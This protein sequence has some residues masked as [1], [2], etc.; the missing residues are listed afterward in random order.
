MNENTNLTTVDQV[1][2]QLKKAQLEAKRERRVAI[3]SL[4][5]KATDVLSDVLDTT[6]QAHEN[7][8]LRAA[9]VAINLYVQ[10]DNSDRQ[11]RALDLQE[12]RL[13]IEEKKLGVGVF[14]QQNNIFLPGSPEEKEQKAREL[15][16]RKKV[17]D[18]LLESFLAGSP[19]QNEEDDDEDSEDE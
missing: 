12:K 5:D 15:L 18:K 8:R 1:E 4:L 13:D 2:L 19:N 10:Q 6:D 17:T 11:D 7:M 16:E 3:G 14:N 9:E